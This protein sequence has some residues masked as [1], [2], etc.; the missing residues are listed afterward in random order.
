MTD[1]YFQNNYTDYNGEISQNQNS[2]IT[3]W[4][5]HQTHK[6]EQHINQIDLSDA[7]VYTGTAGNN[8]LLNLFD[9]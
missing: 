8:N 6:L 1:R 2:R 3:Q 5:E 4:I 9:L 7:S